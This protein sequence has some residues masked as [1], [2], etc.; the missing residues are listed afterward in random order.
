MTLVNADTGEVVEL[1]PAA[2]T[3]DPAIFPR[4]RIDADLIDTYAAA[5]EAGDPFPPVSILADGRIVDGVHRHAAYTRIGVQLAAVVVAPPEG[6]SLRLFAASL[7][8]ANG[9]RQSADELRSL[10]VAEAESNPEVSVSALAELL[11]VP[12]RSVQRWVGDVVERHGRLRRVRALMLLEAGWSQ[13]AT[14]EAVGVGQKTVSEWLSGS[15]HV[16][17]ST[18]DLAPSTIADAIAGLDGDAR[19]AA[20][21]IADTW[22]EQRER[23]EGYQRS[24]NRLRQALAGWSELVGLHTNKWRDDIIA[25]LTDLERER[26]ATAERR[27]HG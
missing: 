6:V 11:G 21:N 7:N 20:Q 4:D 27:L 26:L 9:K 25:N 23:D 12:R 13:R 5:I 17:E 2:L 15:G 14:A 19:T 10:A 22:T 3:Q 18:H 16:A 8:R 1:D 24:A